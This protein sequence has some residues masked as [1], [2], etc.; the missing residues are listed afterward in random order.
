V[1]RIKQM[2]DTITELTDDQVVELQSEIV[3]EFETVEGQDPTPQTVETMTSLADML[4]NVRGEV[5]RREAQAEELTARAAE[6]ATRVKGA[7]DAAPAEEEAPAEEVAETPE[8]KAEEEAE[9]PMTEASI[10]TEEVSE[11]S[12]TKE[13]EATFEAEVE[14]EEKEEE[15]PAAEEEG[16]G[17]MPAPEAE[18]A[19]AELP[20][21]TEATTEAVTADASVDVE[22]TT[23][24]ITNAP[25]E[26]EGQEAPVT[27]AAHEEGMDVEVQ[28]PADR[29]PSIQATEAAAVVITAGADIPGYTA[30][31]VMADYNE[32]ARAMESRL[33]GL[34]RVK[35]GDGEQHIVASFQTKYPESR[36][37]N[38]DTDGNVAKINA[39]VDPRALVASGGHSTPFEVKY[40]IFGF[41]TTDRP[42]RDSLVR[43]QADRGGIRYIQ[44]P[45]LSSYANAVGVWTNAVDTN[46]GTDVKTSLTVSAATE[47][48]VAT[49][50]VT[51][52]LQFGNLMT[53][54]YPELIARHNELALIQ[55]AREAEQY[56]ASKI[57]A[58]S[59]AVTSTS[60]IGVARDFL[61]Q[62]GRASAAYR[63]RHRLDANMPLRVIAP[64]WIKDAMRADLALAMPGDNTI[65][66]T[67]AE[68]E[69]YLGSLGVNITFSQD[70]DVFG[71]QTTG[72]MNE[73][74]DTFTWYIFAE[75][76]FLFLDGGTLDVGIIRDSTLVGTND[77]KMFVETFEGIAKVGV[78]SM[79]VTST[80]SVN[81]VAAALR[82]TTGA[83]TAA[84]IEY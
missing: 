30:G 27:A 51:L 44:P 28:A 10:A 61:V 3:A 82:D 65:S 81:G 64:A 23:Q 12:T 34:R 36:V 29:R 66:A 75:G 45:V 73:F 67:D 9:K 77:Y 20:V 70:L 46:P 33:H 62:I 21:E 38:Q 41:G 35:G 74:S 39:L 71:A 63:S 26:Q 47:L 52:Q 72:G 79:A 60:L 43:F 13:T 76:T 22:A 25:Q 15:A 1:D 55:H 32:V 80:I 84:V 58:G 56:L 8:V 11:L 19:E 2:L 6:A 24:E 78:E 53:R 57:A 5:K 14:T 48:T 37:L 42:I 16:E 68:I 54:A 49:D 4:D 69:G 83:A 7:A 17:E 50:A 31:G 59:I 18:E 40:D